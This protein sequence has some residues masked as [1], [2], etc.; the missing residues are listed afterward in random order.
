MSDADASI[1]VLDEDSDFDWDDHDLS[2][3]HEDMSPAR[4]KTQ[5]TKAKSVTASSKT[6]KKPTKS[7]ALN[8]NNNAANLSV[9]GDDDHYDCLVRAPTET[10]NEKKK[11]NK[12]IEQTYQKK[13]QLEHILLRPDT[14]SEYIS[15]TISHFL[16]SMVASY[17]VTINS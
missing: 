10:K 9:L 14:Y 4:R 5:T 6:R 16:R 15:L 8:S 2:T 12:T 7:K 17:G 3:D 11:T 1:E 13:T